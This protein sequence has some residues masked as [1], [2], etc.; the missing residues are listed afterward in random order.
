MGHKRRSEAIVHVIEIDT[1][2]TT[3][4]RAAAAASSLR[5]VLPPELNIFE[6]AVAADA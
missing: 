6:I 2:L 4:N 5:V 3:R 1:S